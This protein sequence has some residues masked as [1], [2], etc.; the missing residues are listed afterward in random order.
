V[1]MLL[2][3]VAQVVLVHLLIQLLVLQ[4]QLVKM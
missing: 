1:V 2:M 3:V 4:H